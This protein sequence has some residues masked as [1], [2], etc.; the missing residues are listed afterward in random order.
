MTAGF[1][2]KPDTLYSSSVKFL[3]LQ[4]AGERIT[5]YLTGGLAPTGGMA[6]DDEAGR[7]FAKSY[8]AAAGSVMT[9]LARGSTQLGGMAA[10][11]LQM[12]VNYWKADAH[13]SFGAPGMK[14][15]P[16]APECDPSAVGHV[17]TAVGENHSDVPSILRKFWPQGDTGKLREAAGVWRTGAGLVDGLISRGFSV[18]CDVTG[19]NTGDAIDAFA[20][21]WGQLGGAACY[22]SVSADAPL[23]ANVSGTCRALASACDDYASRVEG[24][25]KHLEH[26]AIA[27]GIIAGLGILGTV[28]TLGGSDGAAAGADTAILAA[29]VTSFEVAVEGSAELAVLTEAEAIVAAA[30]ADLPEIVPLVA[31]TTPVGLTPAA[32]G[33]IGLGIFG[34]TFPNGPAGAAPTGPGSPIG[35]PVGPLP[36][37]PYSPYSRM[38]LMDQQTNR[39]WM[40]SLKQTPFTNTGDWADY[41]RRVAGPTIYQMQN[42]T[43]TTTI[44]A[45]GY[46]PA[47]GAV[48][49]AKYIKGDTDCSVYVAPKPE[50]VFAPVYESV[51]SGQSR[52]FAKYGGA[53]SNAENRAKFLEVIVN[54]P[55]ALPY[56]Q[57]LLLEFK[58]PGWVRVEQ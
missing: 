15:A 51:L 29:A 7:A 42:F 14:T 22:G 2:V 20:K 55:E 32:L 12:A 10:G 43:H 45:D 19:S 44:D 28:F 30:A 34:A 36:P 54:K 52:E 11:L 23:L 53:I 13:S 25:R 48:I 3:D 58:I 18:T 16:N 57:A 50:Q 49:E 35:G 33:S 1:A 31:E 5:G 24:Q 9:G 8:D 26:L 37:S 39:A 21:S 46:R 40:A 47:D 17:P 6:G 4:G 56:F 41:Q 38:S 27:A